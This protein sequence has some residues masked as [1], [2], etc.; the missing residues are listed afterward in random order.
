[1]GKEDNQLAKKHMK[2]Y[3]MSLVIKGMQLKS[4]RRYHFTP[5]R[6]DSILN[7]YAHTENNKCW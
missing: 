4:R 3:S 1:M 5:I 2:R 7:T 6:R